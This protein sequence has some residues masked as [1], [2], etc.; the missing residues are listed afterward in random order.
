MRKVTVTLAAATAILMAGSLIAG[1]QTT[2][3]A[4]SIRKEAKNFTPVEKAAC[5]PYRGRWCGPFHTRVC[6]YGRCWC[7]HC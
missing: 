2:R 7:V 4:F 6:R 1:A 5:G 3:G